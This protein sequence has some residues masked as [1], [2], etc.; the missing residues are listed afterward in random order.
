MQVIQQ[1]R[2]IRQ[3]RALMPKVIC[4]NE[5]MKKREK[6]LSDDVGSKSCPSFSNKIVRK[7][8]P[9]TPATTWARDTDW[10]CCSRAVFL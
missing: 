3:K 7:N 4:M 10:E 2:I 6:M 1:Y 5:V 9:L 8:K